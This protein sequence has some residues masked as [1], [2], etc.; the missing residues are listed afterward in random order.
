M[1]PRTKYYIA[2]EMQHMSAAL[3]MSAQNIL[4]RAGLPEDYFDHEDPGLTPEQ[5]FALW[6]ASDKEY[7]GTDLP[8]VIGKMLATG[9]SGP[10]I[11]AFTCSRL[12]SEGF[13]RIAVFK[14]LAGPFKLE[15]TRTNTQFTVSMRSSI[16]S[17]PL[18]SLIAAMDIVFFVELI[19]T[20][21][22]EHI[23]PL[24]ATLPHRVEGTAE[25]E[26]FIGIPV[27][28]GET[29]SVTFAPEVADLPLV[30]ENDALWAYYEKDLA[31]KLE[32]HGKDTPTTDRLRAPLYKMLPSGHHT[33]DH[34]CR[35]LGLSK[36]T[37]QRQLA[38][39]G[40][41][42]QTVLDT[43]RSDLSLHYLRKHDMNVEEISYLLAYRDPNSFYRAFQ[44]WTGMTPAQARITQP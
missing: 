37:L 10:I 21:T 20:S 16:P 25:I 5:L 4:R 32:A 44:N 1:H 43:T 38:A 19:R 14:P 7:L 23:T 11:L 17:L 15:T 28:T 36:R 3:G 39:E 2:N 42:Y 18:P 40:T 9:N 6:D 34:A 8:L 31:R 22:G 41:T 29:I 27:D 26:Q 30:T 35:R 12:V 33:A 13:D 24:R